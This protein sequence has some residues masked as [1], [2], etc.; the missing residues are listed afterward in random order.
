MIQ[1]ADILHKGFSIENHRHGESHR[2]HQHIARHNQPEPRPIFLLPRKLTHRNRTE[3]LWREGGQEATD[4]VRQIRSPNVRAIL[5]IDIEHIGGAQRD[6]AQL[7]LED[8][9]Q[10]NEQ[11]QQQQAG[12]RV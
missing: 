2:C 11:H 12:R 5:D 3:E 9:I 10:N 4:G 1:I 6:K 7:H 8:L